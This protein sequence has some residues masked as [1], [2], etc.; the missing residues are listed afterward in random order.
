MTSK[1]VSGILIIA[2]AMVLA[3]PAR[4]SNLK[5]NEHEIV[6]GI[7]GVSVA[8]GVVVTVLIFHYRSRKT[9][10]TGCVIAGEN[11]FTVADEKDK[12]VYALSGNTTGIKPGDRISLQG[13]KAK[14]KESG[15]MQVWEVREGIQDL[16]VCS[17]PAA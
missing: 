10:I 17:A 11:G 13:R 7:V 4:A 8:I 1:C 16:G 15:K 12:Q 6:A 14:S 3:I 5:T 2:L 9:A